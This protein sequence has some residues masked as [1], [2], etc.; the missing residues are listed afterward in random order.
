MAEETLT[1]GRAKAVEEGLREGFGLGVCGPHAA[2][3]WWSL[4]N[5]FSRDGWEGVANGGVE[6]LVDCLCGGIGGEEGVHGSVVGW[7]GVVVVSRLECDLLEGSEG[8][9]GYY[10]NV[11][12]DGESRMCDWFELIV[13]WTRQKE[14]DIEIVFVL[15]DRNVM[16]ET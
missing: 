5:V 1:K 16:V 6:V 8:T 7:G 3:A 15:F 2:L 12:C 4:G 9:I 14:R 13:S 10:E 11:G